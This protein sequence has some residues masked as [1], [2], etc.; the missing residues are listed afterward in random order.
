MSDELR[1]TIDA[2]REYVTARDRGPVLVANPYDALDTATYAL[3]KVAGQADDLRAAL[4]EA[5]DL[6]VRFERVDPV[7]QAEFRARIAE[8]RAKFLGNR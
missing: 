1:K 8:L 7:T 4:A 6:F 2:A 5:C 3:V